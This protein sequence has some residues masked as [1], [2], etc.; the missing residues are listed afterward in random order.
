MAILFILACG[1]VALLVFIMFIILKKTVNAIN[2]QTKTYFVDKLQAY[3]N[4]IDEKEQRLNE[5]DELLK[6]KESGLTDEET[7]LKKEGYDF[8]HS[9]IDLFNS[10]EYQNKELLRITKLI[11]EK[12]DFNHEKLIKNFL[13]CINNVDKYEF[14]V[15]LKEKF[16]S[17]IIY[18]VKT[19]LDSELD[20]YMQNFLDEE[21]NEVYKLFKDLNGKFLIEDFVDYLDRLVDLNDPTITIYVSNKKENYDYLSKH[22]KTEVADDIYSGIK[23]VYKDK[24]Y[25]FSLSER[26]V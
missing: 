1:V 14:C 2:S 9:I 18:E 22:I 17:E 24:I 6:N 20:I 10:T 15:R 16:T 21:E 5:I 23:I 12:F 26:N 25:D 11:E 7:V 4:L 3:D 8:D 13:E 19:L